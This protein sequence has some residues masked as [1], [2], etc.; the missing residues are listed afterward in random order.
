MIENYFYPTFENHWEELIRRDNKDV[1]N[2]KD[3]ESK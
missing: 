3:V 1:T 2:S